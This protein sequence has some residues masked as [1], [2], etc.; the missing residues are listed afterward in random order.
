[1]CVEIKRRILKKES[2]TSILPF[3]L[4][5]RE[6]ENFTINLTN[7]KNFL[8]LLEKLNKYRLPSRESTL[9]LFKKYS[10]PSFFLSIRY[11]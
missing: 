5:E 1:M 9:S 3:Q 6:R 8:L 10:N 2:F 4:R 7:K 11:N